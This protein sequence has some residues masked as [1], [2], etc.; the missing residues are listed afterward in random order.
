[1]D[2]YTRHDIRTALREWRRL[3][4]NE[5]SQSCAD[6]IGLTVDELA[7]V[8]RKYRRPTDEMLL[9]VYRGLRSWYS[10]RAARR[11]IT[12]PSIAWHARGG[13]A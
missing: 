7:F 5:C 8:E 13:V 1:M 4:G 6:A 10:Q 12:P 3:P 2:R 11:W 9:R